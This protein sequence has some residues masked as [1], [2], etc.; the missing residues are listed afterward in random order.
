MV[1]KGVVGSALVL[2]VRSGRLGARGRLPAR[3]EEPLLRW[4]VFSIKINN[5]VLYFKRD[6]DGSAKSRTESGQG[7][8]KGDLGR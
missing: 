1:F 3:D 5:N 8:P 4:G 7:F 2:G 6:W